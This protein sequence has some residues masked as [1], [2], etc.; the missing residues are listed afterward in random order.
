MRRI[1]LRAFAVDIAEAGQ[2]LGLARVDLYSARVV[3]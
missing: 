3:R 1:L 2:R